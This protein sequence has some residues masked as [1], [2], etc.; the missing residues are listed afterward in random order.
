MGGGASP[1]FSAPG[2][3]L[4]EEKSIDSRASRASWLL[5]VVLIPLF[6]QK[7]G[8]DKA[9]NKRVLDALLESFDFAPEGPEK[10]VRGSDDAMDMVQR[11]TETESARET[12]GQGEEDTRL[13]VSRRGR[14]RERLAGR[15]R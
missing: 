5:A 13:S 8:E 15:V 12:A 11:E 2:D 10:S 3:Y 6:F 14:K 7:L 9:F 1:A 4:G